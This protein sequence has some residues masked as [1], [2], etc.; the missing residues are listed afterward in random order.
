MPIVPLFGHESARKRILDA[1]RRGALPSSLLIEGPRGIGKQRMALW[2]AQVRLCGSAGTR[3]CGECQSCRYAL[4]LTHPDL[5]W[6]FPRPR[7]DSDL[8][9]AEV[10]DDYREAVAERMR[11]HGLYAPP[12]GMDGIFVGA[13][14][15]LVRAAAI[16]P[17]IGRRKVFVVGD[18]ERMVSQEGSEQ[19]AN[20]F[21]KLLEEPPA[22]TTIILTSSEPGSLLPTVRSR[23]IS[24]RL[25]T[26]PDEAVAEFLEEERVREVMGGTEG[27]PKNAKERLRLAAGAPG[28]L[29]EADVRIGAREGARRLL[30]S[31]TGRESDR[32]RVAFSQSIAG[33]RGGFSDMLD[34]LTVLVHERVREAVD[35]RDER[36]AGAAAR[37]IDAI[38]DAK[39]MAHGNVNP[40]LITASLLQRLSSEL[41]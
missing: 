19:A 13:V 2:L 40:Q 28:R 26:L 10:L 22:D 25:Q 27:V 4:D 9:P 32:Y 6:F 39:A 7:K 17:S 38:E 31:A 11:R 12:S 20:A 14:R 8:E 35:Q 16:S 3:P 37:V 1:D 24:L 33:A 18:A 15:A 30:E 41:R 21:L 34:E 23:L 29:L 5:F 36:R